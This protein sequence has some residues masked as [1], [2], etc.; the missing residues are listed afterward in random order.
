MSRR[1]RA[2]VTGATMLSVALLVAA[3]GGSDS[4]GPGSA[5]N[6]AGD[7]TLS[8]TATNADH[9]TTCSATGP[10]N[11]TQASYAFTGSFNG[12]TGT[13]EEAGTQ[14]GGTTSGQVTNGHIVGDTAS[15]VLQGCNAT[16][17]ISGNP[18]PVQVAGDVTCTYHPQGGGA[19]YPITGTWQMQR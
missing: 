10:L 4:T 18:D 2:I 6:L 17:I 14:V 11:I 15:F 3:C 12:A 7:W 16:G 5:P 19:S 13:C 1:T 9:Q 8:F